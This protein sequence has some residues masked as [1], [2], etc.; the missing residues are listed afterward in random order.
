M[1]TPHRWK[2]VARNRDEPLD[3]VVPR[4]VN[5]YGQLGA[6][7]RLGVS[8]AAVSM[9]LKRNGYVRVTRWEKA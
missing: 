5:T 7:L 9:W 8:Q 1:S 3:A 6:A 4:L 2:E